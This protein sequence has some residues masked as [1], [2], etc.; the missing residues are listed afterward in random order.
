MIDKVQSA[1]NRRRRSALLGLLAGAALMGLSACTTVEGTNAFTDVGTFEREVVRST[2]Q[3]VGMV[4]REEKDPVRVERGPLVMPPAGSAPSA[5]T[6]SVAAIPQ[7]STAVAGNMMVPLTTNRMVRNSASRPEMP[8]MM[9][10][11]SV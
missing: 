5:P 7:A 8:R 9:P 1:G 10:R 3:G 6:Q 4:P 2:L 11:Y